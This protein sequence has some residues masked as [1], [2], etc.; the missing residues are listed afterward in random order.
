M[1]RDPNAIVLDSFAGSGTTAHAVLAQNREDGGNRRFILVECE[2][3]AE[4]ITAERVRRVIR[5]VSSAKDNALKTGLGGTFSYFEL[6]R[7]MRQESLLD[8]SH[9]PSWEKLASY[10]FFTATG[11]EFDP[12]E[13]NPDTGFVGRTE[14]HDV[15]LFYQPDVEALKG[16]ALSLAEARALP[17]GGSRRRL[18]FAPTK[19]LDRDFLHQYRIDFQQLP[20]QIYEAIDRLER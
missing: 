1:L 16:L 9:L 5:G 17:D 13:T 12:A 10:I 20:F 6:G 18:V 4:N 15:F 3:Y 2:D 8:G 11:Q 19:Y 7:P 14:S